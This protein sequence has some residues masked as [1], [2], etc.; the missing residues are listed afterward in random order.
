MSIKR[1]SKCLDKSFIII[2]LCY[3]KKQACTPTHNIILNQCIFCSFFEEVEVGLKRLLQKSFFPLSRVQSL[4][5]SE[6]FFE[7]LSFLGSPGFFISLFLNLGFQRD[8][9][10]Q[11]NRLFVTSYLK[12]AL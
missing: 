10:V 11:K 4:V 6:E 1:C 8:P 5:S 12:V 2:R 9:G 3:L 7:I